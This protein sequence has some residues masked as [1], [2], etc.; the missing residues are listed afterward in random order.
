MKKIVTIIN[1]AYGIR[2]KNAVLKNI[3]V[4]HLRVLPTEQP[5]G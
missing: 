5:I 3:N 4:T 1:V 2:T